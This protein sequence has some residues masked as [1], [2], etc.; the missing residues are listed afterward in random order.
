MPADATH[1]TL[2]QSTAVHSGFQT[3]GPTVLEAGTAG[4]PLDSHLLIVL[5]ILVTSAAVYVGAIRTIGLPENSATIAASGFA[6]AALL[7]HALVSRSG[8]PRSRP[9]PKAKPKGKPR[10]ERTGAA[11]DRAE[12]SLPPPG[13]E[14]TAAVSHWPDLKLGWQ[15][16]LGRAIPQPAT[17]TEAA[18]R[19]EPQPTL[20]EID[21]LE[22]TM[23]PARS[24]IDENEVQRVEKLVRQ[25]AE[26]VRL[27]EE[28]A[29]PPPQ[30]RAPVGAPTPSGVASRSG[31]R[32]SSSGHA[33]ASPD[34]ASVKVA[35][36]VA[37]ALPAAQAAN[38]EPVPAEPPPTAPPPRT[39]A[40]S[41]QPALAPESNIQPP[42]PYDRDPIIAALNA[43]RI[44]VYLEPI[45]DLREQKP[46]H[47]QVSIGLRAADGSVIDLARAEAHL[48]GTGLLP[49][50]DQTRIVQAANLAERLAERGKTG[51]VLTEMH[52]ETLA[53]DGFQRG[54]ASGERTI[55]AFPGHL[56]L[57]FPQSQV[58]HFTP[59]DWQTL[60][61]LSKAGFA[62]AI[63]DITTL[64]MDFAALAPRGFVMARLDAPTFLDGLPA[65]GGLIPPQDIC[66][67][68]AGH[69][70]TL[71]VGRISDDRDL[72]RIFG[73]GVLF[74]QGQLFGAPRAVNPTAQLRAAASAE[75]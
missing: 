4:R 35:S 25:L 29:P 72:A 55:G 53:H 15:A 54:F 56:V 49:L 28:A 64:D 39:L 10:S 7:F 30:N 61:R 46:Q 37:A 3:G 33:A 44:D 11:T 26:N 2:P 20:N 47:F 48:G 45:L 41:K 23:P 71:I 6:V 59:A 63:T 74:G 68:V 24:M 69:G 1:S 62:Y 21:S 19:R 22:P 9:R 16:E 8:A 58:M 13:T 36:L 17:E 5:A 40:A 38:R 67:H 27:L 75:A 18:V 34:T 43:Q 70:L 12:P 14:G 73:F 50:I 51:N 65:E 60:G 31:E 57:A 42:R 66:R 32:S 52:G